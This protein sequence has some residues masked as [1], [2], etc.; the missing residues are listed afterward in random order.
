[1]TIKDIKT[2]EIRNV[3]DFFKLHHEFMKKSENYSMKKS[4]NNSWIFRGQKSNDKLKTSLE[5]TIERFNLKMENA[6][7]FEKGLMREFKRQSIKYLQNIPDQFNY[8]EWFALM[9][10]Y[11]A[12]TRLLDWTYSFFAAAFFAV[13]IEDDIDKKNS[14]KNK[15]NAKK[16]K[17][18]P[19]LWALNADFIINKLEK[20]FKNNVLLKKD[21][22]GNYFDPCG[23]VPANFEEMFMSKKPKEFVLPMNPYSLNERLVLQ[24]GVFLC[25]GNIKKPFEKNFLAL[26]S[27]KKE[28][29]DNVKKYV[30]KKKELKI[31]ILKNLI[32]MNVNSAT[33]FPGLDGFAKSLTISL[34]FPNRFRADTEYIKKRLISQEMRE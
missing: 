30:I 16:N 1:M 34:V 27:N 8:M 25:P 20:E 12:P 11:G 18:M 19:E 31:K 7:K 9:Q 3:N 4:K 6:P 28:L 21:E 24:Q 33:L 23:Q 17:N 15:K 10:H 14:E 2:K 13:N 32:R 29:Q 5:K 26:F 22:D